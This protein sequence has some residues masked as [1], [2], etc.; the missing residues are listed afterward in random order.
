[1]F[2]HGLVN[3][4]N[5]I[6]NSKKHTEQAGGVCDARDNLLFFFFFQLLLQEDVQR[7]IKVA[8]LAR[9]FFFLVACFN[10]YVCARTAVFDGFPSFF[11][12]SVA[13]A[14]LSSSRS[15]REFFSF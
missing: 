3:N 12:V 2:C 1:M 15:Q 7:T 11:L 14:S 9:P 6:N 4:N 13:P 10:V 5:T 8:V